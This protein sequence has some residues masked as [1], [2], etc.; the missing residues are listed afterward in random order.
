MYMLNIWTSVGLSKTA[1]LLVRIIKE[2]QRQRLATAPAMRQ[3]CNEAAGS[4]MKIHHDAAR[5]ACFA[6]AHIFYSNMTSATIM[7]RDSTVQACHVAYQFEK[8]AMMC[9]ISSTS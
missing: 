9:A 6:E 7:S 2:S 3:D 8:Y 1:C 4:E 5:A